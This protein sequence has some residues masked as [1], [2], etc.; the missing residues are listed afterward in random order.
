MRQI[1]LVRVHRKNLWFGVTPLD[2][3]RKQHFLHF[4]A[5]AAVAA[6]QKEVPG[7]LHGDGAGS[8]RF[9]PFEQ[10]SIRGASDTREI[11]A[12]VIFEMLVLNRTN[13]VVEN[14]RTLLVSH[15]DAPL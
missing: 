11:N 13:G 10:I 2:L 8:F 12:P 14:L 6:V 7:Q 5:K 3:E 1:D 15:Q 4:A 9:A